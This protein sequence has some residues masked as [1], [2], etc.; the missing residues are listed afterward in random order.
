MPDEDEEER[1]P[2]RAST[3]EPISTEPPQL[4]EEDY[5]NGPGIVGKIFGPPIADSGSSVQ[6]GGGDM[7]RT[8][9]AD[10]NYRTTQQQ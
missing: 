4:T 8:S 5:R 2:L 10:R 1:A 9:S 7:S 3:G 6:R